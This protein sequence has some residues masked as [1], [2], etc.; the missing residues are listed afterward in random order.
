ML[1]PLILGSDKTMLSTMSGDKSAW[2][3]YLTVGNLAKEKRRSTK[4]NGLILIG[5][6]PKS[7]NSPD[8]HA[9]KRALHCALREILRSLESYERLGIPIRCADG[10]TRLGFPRLASWLADYPEQCALTLVIY[11]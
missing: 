1:V 8:Q 2:P 7:P 9:I 10:H 3:I 11:R 4:C 6:L 5:I